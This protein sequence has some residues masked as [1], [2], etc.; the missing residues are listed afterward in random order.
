MQVLITFL[1]QLVHQGLSYSSVN[2]ARSAVVTLVSTCTDS[3]ELGSSVL[4][5]K[6]M[7]GVFASKPALP[8]ASFTWDVA[9]VLKH[10]KS[11]S[12]PKGLSLLELSRKLATLLALLS[13]QRGQS[14]HLLAVEDCECTDTHLVLRFNFAIKQTRPGKHVKETCI[15]A[16]PEVGLCIVRTFQEY[17]KRTKP[18]RRPSDNRLFLTAVRP[19]KAISRDTFSNWIKKTLKVAG[20]NLALF[21]SHST[22]AAS[23]SAALAAKTPLQTIL[24][25][26][27]W[28]N[29]STFRRFYHK[30][31]V[32]DTSFASS[33][34]N[35]ANE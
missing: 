15:P 14:L 21:S 25:T 20:I 27:G 35:A 8:K 22:R 23:T 24:D 31:V 10:L 33:L 6:F 34:L 1:S 5:Q 11:R 12:P 29:E 19:H 4:L 18:L 28:T 17:V 3:S 7:K 9:V 30:P 13:G 2:S 26:A 32:R 16:Y